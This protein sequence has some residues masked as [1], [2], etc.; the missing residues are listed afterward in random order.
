MGQ[1]WE[2]YGLYLGKYGIF[3]RSTFQLFVAKKLSAALC[4]QNAAPYIIAMVQ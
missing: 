4:I 1:F 3:P 2:K